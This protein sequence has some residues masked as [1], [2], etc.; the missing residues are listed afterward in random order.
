MSFLENIGTSRDLDRLAEE[1]YSVLCAEIREFLVRHVAETGGHLASNLGT[2][3]LTLALHLTFDL[4]KD[5]LVFDVGHQCYTHKLLTGRREGFDTLRQI[6]GLSGFPKP[7]ESVTDAFIAGHA[8][9]SVSVALGFARARTLSKQS[10]SVIALIGDGALTGGLAYEGLC[11]AGGSAEPMIAILNDNGLSITENVGG[12]ARYLSRQRIKPSYLRFKK[13]YRR[14][15][16]VI[17]GGKVL[18]KFTHNLK[19]AIKRVLLHCSMFEE[20]GFEYLGPVDGHDIAALRRSMEWARNLNAPVLLHVIT[21]KGR[22]YGKAEQSP[23]AYHGV[24][25]FDPAIGVQKEK[26]ET[27]SSVFGDTL[28]KLA[29]QNPKIVAISAAMTS[30][31]GLTN[32][33]SRFPERTFDVGIA[34]GHATALTAGLAAG[35][36]LPVFAVY[37]TFL[38]RG[39]DQLL[40]D[41]ALM[42]ARCV[43]AVDRAGIVPGDGETH[44]GIFD[45][46]FLSTVPNLKIYAPATFSELCTML[47]QAVLHDSGPVAIRY[48]KGVEEPYDDAE[49]D[50]EGDALFHVKLLREGAGVTLVAY[51]AMTATAVKAAEL[52]AEQGIAAEVLKLGVLAPLEFDEIAKSVTKTKKLVV[53]EDSAQAGAIGERLAAQLVAPSLLLSVGERFLPCGTVAELRKMCGLDAESVARRVADFVRGA[54]VQ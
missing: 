42:N 35:G 37:S 26:T 22:G 27:F 53:L 21:Q 54:A 2:V 34:E 29:W 5:R 19:A 41:V 12:M 47:T 4:S 23:E 14:F 52:L 40:H 18:Y 45:V 30:G 11:D 46:A 48:P 31:T 16:E 3:E 1:D 50:A 7:Q 32:F 43:I 25:R 49:G 44:Q 17:P 33:A 13:R 51:G 20:M 9:N 24:S 38:Q 6:D 36:M 10:H 8:S 28:V 39:Y 15:V